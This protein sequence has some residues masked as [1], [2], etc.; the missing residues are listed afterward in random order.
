MSVHNNKSK[1]YSKSEMSKSKKRKYRKKIF[2]LKILFVIIITA[3]SAVLFALS[4]LFDIKEIQ[5]YGN[6]RCST[7]NIK[8]TTG[9]IIGSNGFK[10]FA[11]SVKGML[12]LR[13]DRAEERLLKSY[14]YLKSAIVRFKLPNKIVIKVEEREPIAFVESFGKNMLIDEDGYI[15]ETMDK[16]KPLAFPNVTGLKIQ[17]YIPGQELKTSNA[18]KFE[19]LN[20]V[21]ESFK[22]YDQKNSTSLYERI[23]LIDLN[24]LNAVKV[25]IDKKLT[26]NFGDL[27]EFDY[28]IKYLGYLLDRNLKDARGYLDFSSGKNPNFKPASDGQ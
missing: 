21:I 11:G 7:D 24:D 13:Y 1:S 15:L 8:D 18:E 22:E 10:T 28:R 4:P 26:V 2:R 27:R 20:K 14:P 3:I 23:S 9:I 5:V 16:E 6:K 25:V 12:L 19:T 17:N